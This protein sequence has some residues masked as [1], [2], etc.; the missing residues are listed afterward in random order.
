MR[1]WLLRPEGLL[2]LTFVGLIAIGT[3]AL[4]LPVC[5]AEPVSPLDA[6][7]T[8]TSAACVTGLIVVD[9]ATAW[10][11]TGQ[12]VI[13][14][15]VQLGG[16]GVMTYGA[17][18]FQLLG[19]RMSMTSQMALED[20]FFQGAV[21]GGMR[22]ALR[23]ILAITLT[24]ELIGAVLLYVGLRGQDDLTGGAFEACFLSIT[25]FCNAGFAPYTDNVIRMRDSGLL[26]FTLMALVFIGG[27]GYTVVTEVL[28]R[29]AAHFRPSSTL[30]VRWSLHT[31]VV[32]TVS[33]ALIAFGLLGLLFTA[34][35]PET[36]GW[37]DHVMAV[38]FHA[39]SG[40]TAG[41]NAIDFTPVATPA[42]MVLIPLMFVGGSP[43]SCA[44]GIKTT[45]LA[46]WAA[47][48][49]ARLRGAEDVVLFERR[50]PPEIV[51]R[52]GLVIALAVL[53]NAAG[54][55]LLACTDLPTVSARGLED[56]IFEQVS[57]FGTVGLSTGITPLLSPIGKL[58][59]VVSMFVGR[60]GPLTIALV[61][62][63]PRRPRQFRYAPERV[64]IG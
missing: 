41:F 13:M 47:R 8:A 19:R 56:V 28:Q 14:V 4:S 27:L 42:L 39:V 32:L 3:I 40:R 7:F 55:F 50:I 9:T 43:G 51:R 15:L 61:M 63:A 21:R 2:A 59:L 30:P 37:R 48:V 10:S 58:W 33:A 44:G 38:M 49:F 62:L 29:L 17:L 54:V 57:A 45:S 46:V 16:L 64:M 20:T 52:A 5:Q 24:C 35:T 18:A 36:R 53:W 26:M 34:A 1:R 6:F 12:T 60:L 22:S 31:R 11:R 23:K 25:G